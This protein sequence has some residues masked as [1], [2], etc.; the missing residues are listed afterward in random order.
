MSVMRE[1]KL[2]GGGRPPLDPEP[3]DSTVVD[4]RQLDSSARPHD[5]FAEATPTPVDARGFPA[6]P[7]GAPPPDAPPRRSRPPAQHETFTGPPTDPSM[8]PPDSLRTLPV[9]DHLRPQPETLPP[10]LDP[11]GPRTLPPTDPSLLTLP[12]ASPVHAPTPPPP[13]ATAIPPPPPGATTDVVPGA[14]RPARTT[15][16]LPITDPTLEPLEPTPAPAPAPRPQ[17]GRANVPTVELALDRDRQP[18][19]PKPPPPPGRTSQPPPPP[20]PRTSGAF[21][22]QPVRTAVPPPAPTGSRTSDAFPAQPRTSG[23]F[24]AQPARTSSGAQSPAARPSAPPGPRTSGAFPAQP[25]RAPSG[26]PISRPSAR[27]SAPPRPSRTPSPRMSGKLVVV[28]GNDRGEEIELSDSLSIGRALGNDL[29]LADVA[30]SR[31][32]VQLRW[33]GLE[34]VIEDRSSGNGT[35]VNGK[36]VGQAG[37]R[38][39]DLLALGQTVLRFQLA[40]GPPLPPIGDDGEVQGRAPRRASVAPSAGDTPGSGAR[41][42]AHDPR[43][44]ERGKTIPPPRATVAPSAPSAPSPPKSFFELSYRRVGVIAGATLLGAMATSWLA[45]RSS[46]GER[47]GALA[48]AEVS[49]GVALAFVRTERWEDARAELLKTSALAPG[50]PGVRHWLARAETELAGRASLEQARRAR[51]RH[52][53]PEA[54]RALAAIPPIASTHEQVSPML[55]EIKREQARNEAEGT[56]P[57]GEVVRGDAVEAYRKKDFAAAAAAS[58][59]TLADQIRRIAAGLARAD[60][61]QHRGD[62]G[63]AVRAIEDVLA[64]DRALSISQGALSGE[65]R[66]RLQRIADQDAK[67][68]LEAGKLEQAFSSANAAIRVG[69]RGD[70]VARRVLAALEDAAAELCRDARRQRG[71]EQKRTYRRVLKIVPRTSPWYEQAEKALGE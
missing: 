33:T 30:V 22:A 9:E 14:G 34:Y 44:P 50:S 29:V 70:L 5:D 39:G 6:S 17:P 46:D 45:T 23:A 4:P 41:A 42:P 21:A 66:P 27:P 65:L 18:R 49:L 32:H 60:S 38:H 61:A 31:K 43:P 25:V 13:R 47:G 51:D 69:G 2:G 64:R 19:A 7:L 63:E 28:Q 56:A 71:E 40:D 48:R 37:L 62:L 67:A 8:A 52:A 26:E 36:E 3:A 58:P 59:P 57:P 11:T 20:S 1:S 53:W 55:A 15:A 12:A 24:P 35:L 54:R 16:E 68:S 10:G